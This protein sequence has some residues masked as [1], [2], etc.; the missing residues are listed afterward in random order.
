MILTHLAFIFLIIHYFT[1]KNIVR[2]ASFNTAAPCLKKRTVIRIHVV[3]R[4]FCLILVYTTLYTM[5][6]KVFIEDAYH[7]CS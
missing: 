2:R 7:G 1:K 3:Y 5:V 4:H 6:S